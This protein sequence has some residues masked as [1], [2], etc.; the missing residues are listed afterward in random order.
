[1]VRLNPATD[2]IRLASITLAGSTTAVNRLAADCRVAADQ[3]VAVP[4]VEGSVLEDREPCPPFR[5]LAGR[6]G[7]EVAVRSIATLIKTTDAFRTVGRSRGL[8]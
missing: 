7:V 5:P 2:R 8:D 6:A 4:E 3:A 1:V